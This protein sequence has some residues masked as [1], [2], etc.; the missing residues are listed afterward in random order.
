[1][2]IH[3][4]LQRDIKHLVLSATSAPDGDVRQYNT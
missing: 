4:F 1:V 2:D 3:I